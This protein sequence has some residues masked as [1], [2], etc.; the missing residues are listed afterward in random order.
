M[1]ND[2]ESLGRTCA[3]PAQPDRGGTEQ[4]DRGRQLVSDPIRQRQGEIEG[5]RKQM[6]GRGMHAIAFGGHGITMGAGTDGS[7]TNTGGCH[8]FIQ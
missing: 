4:A 8:P 7:G 1:H 2:V 3:A 5:G 6:I